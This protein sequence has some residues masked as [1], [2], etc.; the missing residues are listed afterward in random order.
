[1]TETRVMA[2]GALA[3]VAGS[4]SGST[5][6]T[7]AGAAGATFAYVKS[8]SFTSGADFTTVFDRGVPSH[9]KLT[10]RNP[11]DI[12]FQVTWTGSFPTGASGGDHTLPH[13]HLQFK[14]I[15]PE[16]GAGSA[17][18]YMFMG[19]PFLDLA[20]AEAEDGNT[21][22]IKSKALGMIGPT[23]SGYI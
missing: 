6:A 15:R 17:F 10:K 16:D 5:W 3:F 22:T 13:F 7:A 23:A 9:N 14:S 4:G 19:V 8:F 20:F 11:I 21:M 18:Y 2:E 1:M 12:N